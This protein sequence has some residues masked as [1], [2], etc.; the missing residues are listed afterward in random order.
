VHPPIRRGESQSASRHRIPPFLFGPAGPGKEFSVSVF[1][2]LNLVDLVIERLEADSELL[3]RGGLVAVVLLETA[4]IWLI[5][6]SRKVGEPSGI[7]K[8]GEAI[9]G[10]AAAEC[11]VRPRA[12]N[13]VGKCST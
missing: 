1:I 7:V 9:G 2:L 12:G 6:M 10:W 5:S 13:W 11:C 8:W 3:G 4:W